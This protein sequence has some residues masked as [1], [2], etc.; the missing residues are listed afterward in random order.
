MTTVSID[1]HLVRPSDLATVLALMR[2]FYAANEHP[3]DPAVAGRT[4]GELL[5]DSSVGHAW[6]I[7]VTGAHAGYIVLTYAFSLEFGGRVAVID[8]LYVRPAFQ[9]RGLA[10]AALAFVEGEARAR[11]ARALHLEVRLGNERA[12]GVYERAGFRVRGSRLMSRKLP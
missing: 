2:E 11:G 4:L 10:S 3:F 12:Y 9:G 7:D 6:L 8:E 5:A 1:W